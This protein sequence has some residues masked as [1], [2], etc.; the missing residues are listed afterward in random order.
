[1]KKFLKYIFAAG[2]V[3]AFL[4][5]CEKELDVTYPDGD[6]LCVVEGLVSNEGVGIKLMQTTPMDK[7]LDTRP[8]TNARVFL[9]STDGR[10]E[11][12]APDN[13]GIFRSDTPGTAGNSYCLRIEHDGNTYEA[14]STMP[15]AAHLEHC[16]LQ[17][18]E[19]PYDDVV[20]MEVAVA[21]PPTIPGSDYGYIWIKVWRNGEIYRSMATSDQWSSDNIVYADFMCTRKN[22]DDEEDLLENG[23]RIDVEVLT[24]DRNMF[25]YISSLGMTDA[26]P[27][28]LFTNG[29]LG[30]F[31]ASS[32]TRTNF[33]FDFANVKPAD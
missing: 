13:N 9:S 21:M 33:I 22:E 29:A 15:A 18:I 10:N 23:D 32:V 1:M 20:V 19:M 4:S 14:S 27:T 26:N 2:A 31:T 30:Y 6:T 25:D 24:I 17:W 5:A 12:L 16:T 3:S 28:A 7:P 8:I 11:E